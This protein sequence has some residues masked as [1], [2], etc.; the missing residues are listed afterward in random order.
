MQLAGA[1]LENEPKPAIILF[2]SRPGP[3]PRWIAEQNRF[4]LSKRLRFQHESYARFI[5]ANVS[6]V[7]PAADRK[8]LL[9]PTTVLP[10]CGYL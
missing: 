4:D 9:R 2:Y 7:N 1:I 5:F 8:I 3:A 10:Y 6:L